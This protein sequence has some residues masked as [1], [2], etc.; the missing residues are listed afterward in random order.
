[1]SVVPTSGPA[2]APGAG[3]LF[4]LLRDGQ[5][6]TRAELAQVTGLARSTITQRVDALLAAGLIAPIGGTARTGGRPAARFAWNTASRVVLAVDLGATHMSV[7]LTDLGGSVL[8]ETT[9]GMSIA[10]GP[11]AVLD[12]VAVAAS[13]MLEEAD[14]PELAG[15]GV[16][17]PG[18]VEHATGK[19]TN[20][21]IMPGW[22]AFDVP[23]H[24]GKTFDTTILVDNDVNLMA[25]GEH[26]RQWSS[27]EHVL[28]VKVA[29]GI[30]S[31]IIADG[32]LDRG[33]QGSAG[34]LGHV[35]VASTTAEEIV[36]RC[37]NT[38]CLEAI[39]AGPA[40]AAR[41][42]DAGGTAETLQDIVDAVRGGD[43]AA[44]HA[45]RQAGRDIGSVLATCVSLLNPSIIVLG[46][47]LAEAGEFL[48]AGVRE[49]VYQRSLPLA[50]TGLQIVT[51]KTGIE[52]G[53]LGAS[54]MVI[55]SVLAPEAVD[56]YVQRSRT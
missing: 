39:A 49:V 1:M 25:L 52:A 4:Q 38:G 45:V 6:R 5:P 30:G 16:G 43:V 27:H 44:V 13:E 41:L 55:D 46:G 22:D 21:P 36:C 7:A 18:P 26:S 17:I 19:P 51:S 34:D 53:V 48:L 2:A 35:R 24:L 9:V 42:R 56:A 28:F 29:T 14:Q 10:D 11:V 32:S 54:A 47:K 15:I 50:T 31:G 33:A 3:D 12:R 37:G 23:G 20:P 8:A 40:I